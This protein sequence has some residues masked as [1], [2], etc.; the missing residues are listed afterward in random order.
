MPP[1]WIRHLPPFGTALQQST[2]TC[3]CSRRHRS[4]S[5]GVRAVRYDH[6]VVD[7]AQDVSG[8]EWEIIRATIRDSGWTLLG[9]MNQRRTDFGDSSWERLVERLSLVTPA[10]PVMPSV[11]ERGYRSTQPILDF[12]KPLLPR[13]ERTAQS[14]QQEGPTPKVTRVTRAADRDPMAISEAERL[15]ATYPAGTVAII[16]VDNDAA[17][18]E[19]A[20]LS[21]EWRRSDQLGDWRR[22]DRLLALRTPETARGVEFDGVVVVEPGVF[23]RNLARVGPLYTSLTRANR[24]LAVVHH[25]PLPDGLRRHGRR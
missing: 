19:K 22:D 3:R 13:G 18:L 21:G 2:V 1:T 4:R 9:D 10:G 23:P 20:L 16:T 8:L 11:I 12:A 6:V 17:G 14:L 15:L 25:Q 7:E 24:E 5:L